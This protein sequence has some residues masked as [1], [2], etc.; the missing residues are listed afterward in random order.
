MT[1][2]TE[3]LAT[4]PMACAEGRAWAKKARITSDAEAWAK[5]P[6]WSWM[7]WLL[8][9]RGLAMPEREARLFACDCAE[10]ALA[11]ILHPDPRS[12]KAIEVARR[13]AMG[14]ATAEELAAAARSARSATDAACAA[15]D[16]ACAA[17]AA[18]AAAAADAACAAA[19]AAAAAWAAARAAAWAAAWAAD[20]AAQAAADDAAWQAER[21][22]HY[23]PEMPG[24][25][26]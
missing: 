23:C 26:K 8:S 19:D 3:Y 10:R 12:V 20:V 17:C 7:A 18:A 25:K 5:C 15:A 24:G 1:T 9:Q 21:A 2:T 14:T 13:Y 6:R 16:A 11:R 4:L 22:R